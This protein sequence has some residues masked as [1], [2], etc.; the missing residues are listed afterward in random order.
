MALVGVV[1]VAV[2]VVSVTGSVVSGR[3]EVWNTP[4]CIGAAHSLLQNMDASVDPC[5]DFYQ[6]ACGGFEKRVSF[7]YVSYL[8]LEMEIYL[9]IKI[10]KHVTDWTFVASYSQI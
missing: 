9:K 2:I 10:T 6:Y 3:E 4:G 7:L 8:A 1:L 5:E